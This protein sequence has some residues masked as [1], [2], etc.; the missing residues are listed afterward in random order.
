MAFTMI[1]LTAGS[2]YR[3]ADGAV[4]RARIRATP[5]VE[6]KNGVRTVDQEV[7]VP[8]TSAGVGTKT[9]AATTD[10]ATTPTGNAYRFAVEVDGYIVSQF[11][12]A[13]PN[14]PTSRDIFT[15]TV[16]EEPDLV[17]AT[18]VASVNGRVG[19]VVGLAEA[20]A[21]TAHEADTTGIHG[22]A[23][24][25]ALVTASGAPAN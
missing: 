12:A 22:I 6:M 21:L 11:I 10:P 3:R 2:G 7:I 14:S 25:A 1:T 17:D 8:L 20:S 5:H 13:L 24:T 9:I 18:V 16:L 19:A 4:P 23:D 15:L